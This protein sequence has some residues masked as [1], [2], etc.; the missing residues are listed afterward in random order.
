MEKVVEWIRNKVEDAGAKG[1]VVGMSGGLDSSVVAVLCKKATNVLGLIMPCFTNPEDIEDAK[2]VANLFEIPTRVVDLTPVFEKL[3][4]QLEGRE[5][6]GERDLASANVKPRLRMTTLYYFAN[7]MN[8]LVAGT[9]NKS[10]LSIGYFTK[11]GDGGVDILPI[12]HLL[13]TEVRE[14]AKKLGIPEKI[15]KKIPSAGLWEGQ[16]DEGEIGMSYESLDRILSSINS[17]KEGKEVER[18]KEMIKKAK[19]KRKP[20]EIF[21]P[22]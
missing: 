22:K 19:H 3:F 15:I 7:K 14:L 1:V 16:T 9:G 10:E 21:E 8:Y 2:S 4:F 11:Y 18:V 5:Y 13:K 20:P 12:G 6:T 17:I